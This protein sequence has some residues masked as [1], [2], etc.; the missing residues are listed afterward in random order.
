MKIDIKLIKETADE[1]INEFNLTGPS[2]RNVQAI[3][4]KILEARQFNQDMVKRNKA[5][6]IGV[7]EKLLSGDGEK[8]SEQFKSVGWD[9]KIDSLEKF[10]TDRLVVKGR[11][12]LS[13]MLPKIKLELTSAINHSFNTSLNKRLKKFGSDISELLRILTLTESNEQNG[14]FLTKVDS[15]LDDMTNEINATLNDLQ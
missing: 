14:E 8:V 2:H 3:A 7:K 1:L 4:R 6:I 12:L 13:N 15:Y 9:G 11:A 10:M 5:G